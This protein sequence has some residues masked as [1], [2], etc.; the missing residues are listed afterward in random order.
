MI[1][2]SIF[3]LPFNQSGYAFLLFFAGLIS[4]IN[5]FSLIF[6][7]RKLN[8]YLSSTLLINNG[9]MLLFDSFN[10]IGYDKFDNMKISTLIIQIIISFLSLFLVLGHHYERSKKLKERKKEGESYDFRKRG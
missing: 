3:S 5:G 9:L 6:D 1:S 4:I 7:N 8:Q 10:K 2:I